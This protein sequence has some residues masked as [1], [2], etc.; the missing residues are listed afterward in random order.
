M[1]GYSN[2]GFTQSLNGILTLT[3]GLGTTIENGEI[4]T[5]DITGDDIISNTVTTTTLKSKDFELTG[6]L[7]VDGLTNFNNTSDASSL[8]ST[9]SIIINGGV[10]IKENL[11]A[12]DEMSNNIVSGNI[13]CGNLNSSNN[14]TCIKLECNSVD[15]SSITTNDL[16]YKGKICCNINLGI[17]PYLS[18]PLITS[19]YDTTTEITNFN[20]QTY[21]IN[22]NN[23]SLFIQ[24]YYSI[25]FYNYENIL[26]IIDNSNSS[27]ILYSLITFSFNYI[28]TKIILQYKNINI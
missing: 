21:L 23:N 12:T 8:L 3:D 25:I 4:K 2:N 20:L 28:C 27:S 9:A 16:F 19:I 26:Q 11:Y 14:I 15:C 5:G 7:I 24:P 22:S 13:G 10:I 1:N 17:S 6:D 18:I